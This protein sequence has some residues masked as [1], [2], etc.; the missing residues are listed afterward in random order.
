M[1]ESAL[2][3]ARYLVW[4]NR[5][6]AAGKLLDAWADSWLEDT[7]RSAE[8]KP[9]SAIPAWVSLETEKC[10]TGYTP[11][12]LMYD[13]FLADW[14]KIGDD[15]YLSPLRILLEKGDALGDLKWFSRN[16]N[17]LISW[18]ILTCDSSYDEL[19]RKLAAK[20]LE[21]H[22]QDSFFQRGVERAEG[23]ALIAWAID[24]NDDA[25][26]E[27]LKY[28][29]RNNR[30]SMPIY[31]PT[32][33]P[34]DRVY[35]WGRVTLPVMMLGGRLF[36]SRAADPL[37]TAAILWEGIDTDVVSLVFDY[38]PERLRMMVHNFK[39][40]TVEAGLRL[41][42]L[43]EGIYRISSAPD[44]NADRQPDQHPYVQE[45]ALHRFRSR[46]LLLRP[47]TTFVELKC[48]ERPNP[49]LRPDLAVT[50]GK[51]IAVNVSVTAIVHNLGPAPAKNFSV[52]LSN[53]AGR[54]LATK[55]INELPGLTGFEPR[56][57]S[58]TFKLSE[59]N[60]G[61]LTGLILS[62]DSGDNI[63][64]INEFNNIYP[65]RLGVPPPVEAS[66]KKPTM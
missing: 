25:L 18:R 43:P 39:R 27:S 64:E 17:N 22:R 47:G 19:L 11:S 20:R 6:P 66:P 2:V 8:E 65:L 23:E 9:A 45:M 50:L 46:N 57:V 53:S 28:V 29:I 30:R 7:L 37:P 58:V 52:N 15:L 32:D 5:H 54:T 1:N 38:E 51:P 36:D 31:G 61:D 40:D 12:N 48:I 55:T 49:V 41:L 60:P 59:G 24:H 14:Q 44:M 34:I 10:G 16:C 63:R 4:Y 42:N 26:I 35:P 62:V 21:L 33:P 3:P 56:T 13:Y